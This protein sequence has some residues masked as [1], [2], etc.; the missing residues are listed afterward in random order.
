MF[1]LKTDTRRRVLL[2]SLGDAKLC[3]RPSRGVALVPRSAR[4][5]AGSPRHPGQAFHDSDAQL[6]GIRG[7]LASLSGCTKSSTAPN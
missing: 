5:C 2:R 4:R 3:R 6:Q 1:K 7:L